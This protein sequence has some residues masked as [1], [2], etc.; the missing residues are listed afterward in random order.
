MVQVK[1]LIN[2]IDVQLGKNIVVGDIYEVTK[3]RSEVLLK[4][5]ASSENK[6]FVEVIAEVK[7]EAEQEAEQEIETADLKAK[8]FETADVKP[9][10]RKRNTNK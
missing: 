3:E 9:I 8:D 5:N 10:K 7:E 2:Y 1:A 6:P 4:G